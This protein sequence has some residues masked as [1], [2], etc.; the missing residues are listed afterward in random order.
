MNRTVAG[1]KTWWTVPMPNIGL[2]FCKGNERTVRMF[3]EAW[4]AYKVCDYAM[5]YV[6]VH[7]I[8]TACI[9]STRLVD[10]YL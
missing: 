3:N 1:W 5:H 8:S 4:E 2:F 10:Y 6:I 9:L 7:P